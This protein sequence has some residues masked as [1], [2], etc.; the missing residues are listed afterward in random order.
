MIAVLFLN[1]SYLLTVDKK[2]KFDFFKPPNKT[3]NNKQLHDLTY[4]IL[5]FDFLIIPADDYGYNT[6]NMYNRY[7]CMVCLSSPKLVSSYL[8][9]ISRM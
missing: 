3:M 9:S 2:H 7:C 8:G 4:S 6:V 5:G 1:H